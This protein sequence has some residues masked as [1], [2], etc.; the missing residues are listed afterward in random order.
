MSFTRAPVT[1][2]PVLS[3]D[4]IWP[5]LEVHYKGRRAVVLSIVEQKAPSGAVVFLAR[6][7]F[8]RGGE[9]TV[10]ANQLEADA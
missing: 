10:F 8:P 7:R 9:Q 3:T 2:R 1:Q 5:G 6:L 4:K